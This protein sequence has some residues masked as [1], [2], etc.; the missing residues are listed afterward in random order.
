MIISFCLSSCP[1]YCN[2]FRVCLTI[3]HRVN[4]ILLNPEN[5]DVE[6]LNLLCKFFIHI[7][8]LILPNPSFIHKR[9]SKCNHFKVAVRYFTITHLAALNTTSAFVTVN[10]TFTNSNNTAATNT[11]FNNANFYNGKSSWANSTTANAKPCS[12]GCCC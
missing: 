10:T 6:Y 12:S 2:N 1:V 3:Y 11:N 4:L 7:T 9:G 5:T 8:H